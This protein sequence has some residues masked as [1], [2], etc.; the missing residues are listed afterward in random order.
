[1][2]LCQRNFVLVEAKNTDLMPECCESKSTMWA[3][4]SSDL[5]IG[6]DIC[7]DLHHIPADL[8]SYEAELAIE[9]LTESQLTRI[10]NPSNGYFLLTSTSSSNCQ[11]SPDECMKYIV[12]CVSNECEQPAPTSQPS[13]GIYTRPQYILFV[14]D[15]FDF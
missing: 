8:L 2:L 3:K 10:A 14:S 15:V 9:C 13:L 7:G 11:Q 5:V 12:V 1:M 6:D 4:Y